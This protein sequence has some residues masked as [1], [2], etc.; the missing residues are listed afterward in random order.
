MD[1]PI[2]LICN[3]EENKYEKSIYPEGGSLQLLILDLFYK[4]DF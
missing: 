1:T 4:K 3:I 2:S